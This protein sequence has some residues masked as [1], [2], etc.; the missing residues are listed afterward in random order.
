MTYAKQF[1]RLHMFN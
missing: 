1:Q